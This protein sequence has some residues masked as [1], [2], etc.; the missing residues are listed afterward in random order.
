M[1]VICGDEISCCRIRTRERVITK[2]DIATPIRLPRMMKRTFEFALAILKMRK[3][4]RCHGG[5]KFLSLNMVI[6][7][8]QKLH[9]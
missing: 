4:K 7:V 2:T 9:E 1:F 6:I 8:S 3:I 5:T